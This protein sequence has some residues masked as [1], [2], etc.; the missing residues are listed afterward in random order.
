MVTPILLVVGEHHHIMS[1]LRQQSCYNASVANRNKFKPRSHCKTFAILTS[2]QLKF[3]MNDFTKNPPASVNPQPPPMSFI[4]PMP[5]NPQ[6]PQGFVPNV[7]VEAVR[8][9]RAQQSKLPHK[10]VI[11][12]FCGLTMVGYFIFSLSGN[13]PDNAHDSS[14]RI[15]QVVV[16]I[17]LLALQIYGALAEVYWLLIFFC[18]TQVIASVIVFVYYITL[19]STVPINSWVIYFVLSC[20]LHGILINSQIRLIKLVGVK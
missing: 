10:I 7:D 4:Y 3:K 20:V 14:I 2:Y 11:C 12:V 18:I 13:M 19:L 15:A 16:S 17:I 1:V 9:Q 6:V 8:V 5:T